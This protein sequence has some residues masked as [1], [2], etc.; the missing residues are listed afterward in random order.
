LRATE[1]GFGTAQASTVTTVDIRM[2][3]I[4]V[5]PFEAA[6]LALAGQLTLAL[7]DGGQGAGSR[8]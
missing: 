8:P 7:V 6:P 2:M 4:S 3:F 5:P 1:S